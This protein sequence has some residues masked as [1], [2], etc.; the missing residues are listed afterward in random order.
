MN[1]GIKVTIIVPVYNV[2][3]YLRECVN[4]ILSQT[5]KNI[6]VILI[7]DGSTDSSG[8]ICEEYKSSKVIVIHKENEGLSAARNCG[9]ELATGDYISFVDSDDYLMPDM[10]SELLKCAIINNVPIV[11]CDYEKDGDIRNSN[12]AEIDIPCMILK[13]TNAIGHLFDQKGYKCYAWNKLYKAD[14]FK[15]TRYPIGRYFEDIET[16]YKLFC[17]CERIAYIK[18][19]L[20]F[21]RVRKESITHEK[22]SAKSY[23]LLIAIDH[24]LKECYAFD[25]IAYQMLVPGYIVYYLSFINLAYR[26]K[27]AVD[28][29]EIKLRYFIN[30]KIGKILGAKNITLIS[31]I[32]IILFYRA[33]KIY[34]ILYIKYKNRKQ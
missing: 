28:E 21:Y 34:K 9:L 30:G 29:N 4:S 17:Q 16:S 3:D 5:Y 1:K 20:Y 18:R 25:Y 8:N 19:K 26:S 27:V 11:C 15:K 13:R 22:F 2:E 32:Q 12:M 10:I 23:D 7:D 24:V 6:E 31:K 14:L 33:P